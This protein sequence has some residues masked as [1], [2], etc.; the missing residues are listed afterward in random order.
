[1]LNQIE[2][3]VGK[4][5]TNGEQ[6]ISEGKRLFGKKFK[7]IYPIEGS[8][9]PPFTHNTKGIPAL[10]NGEVA[11]LNTDTHWYPVWKSKGKLYEGDS[12]NIKNR[13]GSKYIDYKNPKNFI[14]G[15]GE[16][17]CGPRSLVEAFA[18]LA[19]AR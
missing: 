4:G 15:P 18:A 12:Y 11:I 8:S 7:G 3:R 5:I 9:T 10:K 19:R 6:I 1:M 16:A 13:L 17:N 2:S 14:Q